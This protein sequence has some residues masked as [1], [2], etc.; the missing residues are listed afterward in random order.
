[1][2][3]DIDIEPM[4]SYMMMFHEQATQVIDLV[5]MQQVQL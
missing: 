1:M 2:N 5:K 3:Y 4:L